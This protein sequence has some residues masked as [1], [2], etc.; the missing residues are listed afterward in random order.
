M[1][2]G[3]AVF[4]AALAVPLTVAGCGWFGGGS[5]K[6]AA[7][8]AYCPTPFTVQ[9]TQRLTHFKPGS[10]RD[11]RDVAFEALLVR[12]DAACSISRNTLEV[13]VFMQIAVNAGPSVGPGM[14]RVPFFVRVMDASGTVV[15][16]RDDL[17]DYK[18]T[19]A[20]PRAMSREELAIKL[21]FNELADLGAYRIAVGLK[22]TA[23]ELEFNRRAQQRP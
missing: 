17:A 10:G 3:L 21:R 5:S 4:A 23:D 8:A 12:T 11:P 6:E 1:I 19:A 2:R 9:D 18:L 13:S 15:A 22:P 16:G 14:T 7:A 20:S